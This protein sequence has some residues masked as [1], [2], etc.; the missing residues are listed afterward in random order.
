MHQDQGDALATLFGV[1]AHDGPD[2]AP[3]ELERLL[4]TVV[5]GIDFDIVG[6]LEVK[7]NDRDGQAR[8]RLRIGGSARFTFSHK[9]Q[10][11][12][13]LVEANFDGSGPLRSSERSMML[14]ICGA[15]VASFRAEKDGL[16]IQSNDGRGIEMPYAL[17][18]DGI[19][20]E[21]LPNSDRPTFPRRIVLP[22]DLGGARS[23]GD[24]S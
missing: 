5:A 23:D 9:S 3:V 10:N 8:W 1:D 14:A 2:K 24:G 11:D 16:F 4:G 21:V 18:E 19:I 20:I 12:S 15:S 22:G 7:G 13:W 17:N 6:A